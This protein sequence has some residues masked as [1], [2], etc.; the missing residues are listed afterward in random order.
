[1]SG[2]CDH[3]LADLLNIMAEGESRVDIRTEPPFPEK[4]GVTFAKDGTFSSWYFDDTGTHE[5]DGQWD[6]AEGSGNKTLLLV[7]VVAG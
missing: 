5:T 6:L 1:M 7:S 3:V 4:Y 2:G